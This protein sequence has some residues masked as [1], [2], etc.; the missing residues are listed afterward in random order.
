MTTTFTPTSELELQ[1][2]RMRDEIDRMEMVAQTASPRVVG[3][4]LYDIEI[5]KHHLHM[6]ANELRRRY[7]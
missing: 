6:V 5:H 7:E 2:R 3:A 4:V 1:Y